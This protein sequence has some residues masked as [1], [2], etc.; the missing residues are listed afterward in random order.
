ML[1]VTQIDSREE[2]AGCGDV[3]VVK[4]F[5]SKSNGLC[6]HRFESCSPRVTSFWKNNYLTKAVV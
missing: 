1:F 3:R 5:D 2:T 6:P 4:E